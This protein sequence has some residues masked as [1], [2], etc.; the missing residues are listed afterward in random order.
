LSHVKTDDSE[1]GFFQ[2]ILLGIMGAQFSCYDHAAYNDS[3]IVCTH[4]ALD[5]CVPKWGAR[6][7]V[8]RVLSEAKDFALAPRVQMGHDRVVVNV[9][10]FSKWGGLRR[11][12][13]AVRRAFPHQILSI[14]RQDL[15]HYH[16]GVQF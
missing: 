11:N 10:L 6:A 8:D 16:C 12:W 4:A 15:V 5:T 9:A 13:Y 3:K 1:D 14:G 7:D 2:L